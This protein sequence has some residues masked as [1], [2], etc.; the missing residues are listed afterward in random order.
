MSSPYAP[1]PP[2]ASTP[3]KPPLISR[4][5]VQVGAAAAVAFVLGIGAGGAS[6]QD[7]A[8]PQA[9]ASS[10]ASDPAATT[11][12]D[13]RAT[14][15]DARAAELDLREASLN[16]R[17][18]T[19]DAAAIADAGTLTEKPE[20][21]ETETDAGS[22]GDTVNFTMPNFVGM[23]LQDAQDKVQ[24][25]GIFYSTSHDVLASRMQL[26]DSNWKVC[27]QTP[28]AGTAIGGDAADFEGKFDFG[29]VKLSEDCP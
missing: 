29:S 10:S 15:L 7:P 23:V 26:M 21:T 6:A 19:L 2:A 27:D 13:E 8:D 4:R 20:P 17:Q 12:L 18:A 22:D 24:T 28:K 1:L 16:E 3:P 9:V 25:Y 5:G 14:A 11:A